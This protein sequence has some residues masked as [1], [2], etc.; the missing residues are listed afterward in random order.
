MEIDKKTAARFRSKLRR[1]PSGCLEFIGC[2]H[3][4]G[5]GMMGVKRVPK[6]AHRI[7][8]MLAYGPLPPKLPVVMHLCHNPLC[9]EPAHLRAGTAKQNVRMSAKAARMHGAP[10]EAH[11]RALLTEKAVLAIRASSE[12][13]KQ[14]SGRYGVGTNAIY[15]VLH[16]KTWRHV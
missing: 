14:M 13:V 9:C 4:H 8:Y 11:P 15:K 5:Y 12:N 10:G 3:P 1:A 2:T 6:L 16:R 7:A